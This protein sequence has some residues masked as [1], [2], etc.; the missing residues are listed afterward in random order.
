[1]MDAP[2]TDFTFYWHDYETFGADPVRDRAS[3]FAGIRT[4]K[5]FNILGE[6]LVIF[7]K[8]AADMLPHPQACLIT[9]ITPQQALLQGLPEAE[10]IRR[11][12]QQLALA[13]TCALG[14]NSVRFDD[15][16]TRHTLY[17]NFYDPYTREWQNGNSRWDIIDMVRMCCALRPQGIEWPQ[18]EDGS[19]SFRLEQLT[20]ANGITHTAAHDA[21]SDVYATIEMARLIKNRQPKLFDYLFNLRHKNQVAELLNVVEQTPVLHTS[22]MFSAARFCTTLVMPLALH[23]SNKNA[24]ISYD[25][26][27]DPAP[28]IELNAKQ[29]RERLYTP[30]AELPQGIE[31]IALKTIHTNRCPAVATAKLLDEQVAARIQLDL[32]QA[33]KHYQQ[34]KRAS[35]LTEKLAEVFGQQ[36]FPAHNDP[37]LMLYS[38]GFFS[39][40]DKNTMSRVR[41]SSP[42]QLRDNS[43][44]FE[45]SRLPEMLFRYRARNYSDTL[46][47]DEK[48][49]W[50][51]YCYQRL[52]DP[53]Y[54]AS[55]TLEDYQ[56]KIHT[57]LDDNATTERDRT[58][59]QTLLD[60]TDDLL[61]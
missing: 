16:V 54:G 15:E 47:T 21:L 3:Q 12:H 50:Q 35:G 57:A 20:A 29:I 17:R 61:A 27:V 41:N 34:L 39:Q 48:L 38:G 33:R 59:L 14:Y 11:I 53:Q 58:I 40:N 30:A 49:H 1:M 36:D 18:H 22:A 28:L 2:M 45:D 37:D 8:P 52:T 9:G 23:P 10:F 32:P 7:C 56:E 25:L 42:E 46:L 13:G 51:E 26:S 4:D 6:P 44:S 5:D 55:I 24:V 60:Y 19:P 31:R 43:F